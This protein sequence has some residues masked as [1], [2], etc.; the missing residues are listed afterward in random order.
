MLA[1][2][3][4]GTAA[5][6][7]AV[8]VNSSLELHTANTSSAFQATDA[9]QVNGVPFPTPLRSATTAQLGVSALA[10]VEHSLLSGRHWFIGQGSMVSGLRHVGHAHSAAPTTSSSLPLVPQASLEAAVKSRAEG[11]VMDAL[12]TAALLAQNGG[13]ELIVPPGMCIQENAL[14]N[15]DSGGL[16]QERRLDESMEAK[17]LSNEHF[18]VTLLAV[19]DG[20]KDVYDPTVSEPQEGDSPKPVAT[21]CGVPWST[22]FHRSGLVPEDI[23]PLG[24]RQDLWH[25]KLYPKC[26]ASHA[27]KHESNDIGSS[28]DI[29][30][31]GSL[32]IPQ[33]L[34]N[35]R[36]HPAVLFWPLWLSSGIDPS[37]EAVATWRLASRCS[38]RDLLQGLADPAAEGMHK[39]HVETMVGQA[40]TAKAMQEIVAPAVASAEKFVHRRGV[41]L[42]LVEAAAA[43][44]GNFTAAAAS[45]PAVASLQANATDNP[46]ERDT[47]PLPMKEVPL[48]WRAV[49]SVRVKAPARVDV[50]GGWSDT[51]PISYE[52]GGYVFWGLGLVADSVPSNDACLLCINVPV[53]YVV[54]SSCDVAHIRCVTNLAVSV[55]ENLPIEATVTVLERID[56]LGNQEA[57]ERTTVE[58]SPCLWLSTGDDKHSA[59]LAISKSRELADCSSPSAPAAL[60]KAGLLTAKIVTLNK[61]EDST[62]SLEGQLKQRLNGEGSGLWIATHSSLPQGSGLGTSSIMAGC[63]LSALA[64]VTRCPFDD[65]PSQENEATSLLSG[66]SNNSASGDS[67]KTTNTSDGSSSLVHAVLML[68]QLMTTGGGWQDQAGGC[69]PWAATIATSKP[70]LPLQVRPLQPS[71]FLLYGD[72]QHEACVLI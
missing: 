12:M 48:G 3:S 23:W 35:W 54:Y 70:Q 56:S 32:P 22:F 18:T 10:V 17:T 15:A 37:P 20:I 42:P 27:S 49:R 57:S 39:R 34:A 50:A 4:P 62:G 21:V 26:Y 28:G 5:H 69:S 40:I 41:A 25:A 71:C 52:H 16:E 36:A 65:P 47:A 44:A 51:P 58:A 64:H 31:A 67:D 59:V 7:A 46:P 8:I 9:T 43:E 61:D 38:L 33:P 63:L 45:S 66:N 19:S 24:S 30:S 13:Y 2:L 72:A 53:S 29:E 11:E 55:D 14:G 68:E 60:L 1:H 6:P